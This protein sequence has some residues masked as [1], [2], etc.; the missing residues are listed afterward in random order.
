MKISFT[1][2]RLSL[3]KRGSVRAL[4]LLFAIVRIALFCNFLILPILKPQVSME[5]CICDRIR[6]VYIS[7]RIRVGRNLFRRHIIP[8]VRDI[9]FK[10]FWI[11]V[12]QLRYSSIVRPRKLN[13]VTRSF[14]WL[15]IYCQLQGKIIYM[16]MVKRKEHAF[17]F[18][19]INGQ[20]V[21][22]KPFRIAVRPIVYIYW[23]FLHFHVFDRSWVA[24]RT[25]RTDQVCVICI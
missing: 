20:L 11:C 18:L 6:D 10:I 1:L 2:R 22:T 17:C 15:R 25:Q 19:Y 16:K 8:M 13:S 9:L 21:Y 12:V 5:N 24:K 4:Y 14:N 7:F 3:L 23:Y